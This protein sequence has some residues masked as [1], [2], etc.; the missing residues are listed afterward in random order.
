MRVT[1]DDG[2]KFVIFVS[3][4]KDTMASGVVVGHTRFDSPVVAHINQI[5]DQR[6]GGQK[7]ILVLMFHPAK[8]FFPPAPLVGTRVYWKQIP[9]LGGLYRWAWEPTNYTD[10][11]TKTTQ[12]LIKLARTL[13]GWKN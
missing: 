1:M 8:V 2:Q 7:G 4:D 10:Y 13:E 9:S 5:H 12:S 6:W 11:V 3:Q